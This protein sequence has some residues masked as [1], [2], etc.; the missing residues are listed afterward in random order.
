MTSPGS[1]PSPA[2]TNPPHARLR[3]CV[4]FALGTLSLLL[5]LQAVLEE[6]PL[7]AAWLSRPTW[8]RLLSGLG[9]RPDPVSPVS[10]TLPL[11]P[12]LGLAIG[13]TSSLLWVSGAAA[14]PHREHSFSD[15]LCTWGDRG[16]RW[17]LLPGLWWLLSTLSLIAGWEA[18]G[19]LL[20]E[21]CELWLAVALAGWLCAWLEMRRPAIGVDVP[22]DALSVGRR[23]S[24]KWL[25]GAAIAAYVVIMTG[26]NWGLWFNLRV[27]HGDSAM[28][29]EHLW[30]LEHGKGFRSYLDQGL[31]L[32]EHIQVIHLLLVPLHLLW[33]SHLLLELCQALVMALGAWPV[34]RIA[35]RHL[36]AE[37]PE[38]RLLQ[39]TGF[40]SGGDARR[41]DSRAAE[42][43]KPRVD[44]AALLLACA[45][46]LYVPLQY[47]DITI[48]LKTFRPN[49]LGVPLLLFA[50]DALEQR[51]YLRMCGWLAL[52]LACQEDYAIVI[53]LLGAWI[54]FTRAAPPAAD[55]TGISAWRR[56]LAGRAHRPRLLLGIGMLAFGIGYLLLTFKVVLPYFRDGATIHY[57]SYFEKFGRTPGEIVRTMITQPQRVLAEVFTVGGIVYALRLL[58]PLGGLPLLSPGRL[59]TAAPLFVLLCLN[60]LAMQV[61]AP[62]HHFH[63]PVVPLLFWAAAAELSGRSARAMPIFDRHNQRL[64]DFRP[65]STTQGAAI[66]RARFACA[67]ALFTGLT[68]TLTPLG[69]K[70][71]DPGSSRYWRALY[72]PNERARAFAKVDAMIPQDA[73]VASTDFVH[74]R[75]THR[76]RSY[77]YSDY[78]REVA[79]YEDRVPIDTGYIVL[80]I[81]HP[82]NTPERTAA[83]RQSPETAVREL[84]EE[85]DRWELL[86]DPTNGYYIILRRR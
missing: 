23:P 3:G 77:D 32:G 79:E 35:R 81:E 12:T 41:A 84:R 53:G 68:T 33:P 86:P 63:A 70:F 59:L 10:A 29:E 44:R 37:T 42:V 49:S 11:L 55:A 51:R 19:E 6:F 80:D 34:Y 78:L 25:L 15:R 61:P 5:F 31:F 40:L 20:R 46:L 39:E 8:E 30:N 52:V 57:A 65:D 36:A 38:T 54:M 21:S 18:L 76:E 24:G 7:A 62:V 60:E 13:L 14:L 64:G 16:W 22:V 45:Y 17:C 71:W 28:Y 47:L 82:Y 73:R 66:R 9:G 50:L 26:M 83:L 56:E 48:D 85:P 67:C 74:A 75:F 2:T 1:P 58:V 27:P 4:F 43:D 72:V 69:L